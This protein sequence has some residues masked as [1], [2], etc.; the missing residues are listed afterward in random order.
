MATAPDDRVLD[1]SRRA[2]RRYGLQGLTA[3]RIAQEAGITTEVVL[4]RALASSA[5]RSGP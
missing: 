1:A 3:E 4:E 2:L 5:T